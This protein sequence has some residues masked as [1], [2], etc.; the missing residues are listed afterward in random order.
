[1]HLYNNEQLKTD[2]VLSLPFK[3]VKVP[4]KPRMNEVV[5]AIYCR[6]V[7]VIAKCLMHNIF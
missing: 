3:L 5:I 4:W 2:W 7:D 1:M 6:Y